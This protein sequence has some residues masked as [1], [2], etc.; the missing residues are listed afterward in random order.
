MYR[1]YVSPAG[2]SATDEG[3]IRAAIAAAKLESPADDPSVFDFVENV[4]LTSI[5]K[6]QDKPYKETVTAF[7]MRFQQFTSPV[8]AKGL[9]DT[10]FYRY[11]RLVSL[12]DVGSE[13]H[14][15]GTNATE[16]H[17]ANRLRLRSWPRTMLATRTH[18]SKRSEDVRARINLL[19]E[20]PGPW[21]LSL[22]KWSGFNQRFKSLVHDKPSP[23][24][25]DEYLI[26]QTLIGIWPVHDPMDL[27][28][29]KAYASAS[30]TTCLKPC[31]R[32]RKIQAG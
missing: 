16:F 11:N 10:A 28:N 29:R 4:L 27:T 30:R 15:F 20:M 18:D 19:S 13:L 25:N 14:R 6:D 31:E 22:K 23:S 17:R 7:A 5:S 8:M 32:R 1:T 21:R 24:R 12:N 2:I 26:Y 9:E 3:Y